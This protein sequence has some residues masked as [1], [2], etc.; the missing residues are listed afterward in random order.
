MQLVYLKKMTKQD[1]TKSVTICTE[2]VESFW[3]VSLADAEEYTD[4]KICSIDDPSYCPDGISIHKGNR[5]LKDWRITGKEFK[6]LYIDR[7]PQ[8]GD[9]MCVTKDSDKFI[10]SIVKAADSEYA[11]LAPFFKGTDNYVIINLEDIL[12]PT[13]CTSSTLNYIKLLNLKKNI[14]FTG[15]PGTGKT[16]IAKQIAAAQTTFIP[17]FV[18]GIFYF[19]FKNS[20]KEERV[21]YEALFS[22]AIFS[23]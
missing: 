8:V 1:I 19:I 12:D 20:T 5:A 22:I 17:F 18:A 13:S 15:A 2:S 7:D 6:K 21:R 3:G 9:I 23:S 16:F 11:F 14:V 4:I 10:I